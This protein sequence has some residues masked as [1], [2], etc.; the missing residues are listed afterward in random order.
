MLNKCQHA[1]LCGFSSILLF[2]FCIKSNSQCRYKNRELEQQQDWLHLWQEQ[3]TEKRKKREKAVHL[4]TVTGKKSF[5]VPFTFLYP[6]STY[7]Y[8]YFIC[9]STN[10]NISS[11]SSDE[12]KSPTIHLNERCRL[13]KR[14]KM[15]MILVIESQNR[16]RVLSMTFICSQFGTFF[17]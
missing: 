6:R 16:C 9:K 10:T 8:I 4:F 14:K 7:I 2:F 12:K 1:Y 17:I 11:K 15:M 3:E 5:I 13:K